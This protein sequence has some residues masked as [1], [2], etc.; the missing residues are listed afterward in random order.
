VL[1]GYK[2]TLAPMLI[3]GV[4]LWGIGLGGGYWLA[5]RGLFSV[6]P[7]GSVGLWAAALVGLGV[8]AVCLVWLTLVVSQR[9]A[10]AQRPQPAA[11]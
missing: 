1:R 5:Y 8:A 6:P 7:L 4:S 10:N 3:Y 2:V 11:P 9:H